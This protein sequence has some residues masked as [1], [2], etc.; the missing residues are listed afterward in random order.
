M[1]YL[2]PRKKDYPQRKLPRLA[3]KNL[4]GQQHPIK[5]MSVLQASKWAKPSLL[6]FPSMRTLKLLKQTLLI[7]KQEQKYL[8]FCQ[9]Y[10]NFDATSKMAF[11]TCSS[12]H[13]SMS[14]LYDYQTIFPDLLSHA[15]F[16]KLTQIGQNRCI[17]KP[18]MSVLINGKVPRPS[19]SPG[20][21]SLIT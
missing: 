20:R 16:K 7:A 9:T 5:F 8:P 19:A 10:Q 3:N 21:K 18:L 13:S 11:S 6:R 17:S 14:E 12:A 2:T 15:F 1:Q 4:K